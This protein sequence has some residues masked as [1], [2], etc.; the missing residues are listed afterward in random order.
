MDFTPIM[1]RQ[2][3]DRLAKYRGAL[4]SDCKVWQL[5]GWFS[6]Y[7]FWNIQ[8]CIIWDLKTDPFSNPYFGT[9]KHNRNHYL[10]SNV[11]VGVSYQWI[12]SSGSI[13]HILILVH[14]VRV[15]ESGVGGQPFMMQGCLPNEM[16]IPCKPLR[17]YVCVFE[18]VCVSLSGGGNGCTW[19]ERSQTMT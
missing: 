4:Y 10:Y 16:W 8:R 14:L 19:R 18:L 2:Q 6:T 3:K 7:S 11:R 17:V 15:T 9:L 12:C 13:P 1:D 5:L